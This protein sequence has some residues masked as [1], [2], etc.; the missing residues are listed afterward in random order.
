MNMNPWI[1]FEI[2]VNFFQSSLIVYFFK[3]QLN[4]THTNL[5]ADFSCIFCITSWYTLYLFLDIPLID[6]VVFLIPFIYG[7]LAFD[8]KWYV[9]LFWTLIIALIFSGGANL[10]IAFY[11]GVFG[12]GLDEIMG[13]THYRLAFVVSANILLLVSVLAVTKLR[14]RDKALPWHSFLPL[15]LLNILCLVITELLFSM[16]IVH[17]QEGFTYA[18]ICLFFVSI[19]S[20]VLYEVMAYTAQRHQQDRIEIERLTT[21]QKYNQEM[22]AVYENIAAFKH[23]IK[24]QMEALTQ[25]VS[26]TGV[27]DSV[28]IQ[29][30]DMLNAKADAL[31]PFATG[32]IAIDALLTAKMSSMK[33]YGVILDFRPCPLNE[34]P[35]EDSDFCTLLGNI[36][37]NALEGIC[38]LPKTRGLSITLSLIR[39]WDMFYIKC[40]NPTNPDAIRRVHGVFISSKVGMNHGIGMRSID[41]IAKHANGFSRFSHSDGTFHVEVVLPYDTIKKGE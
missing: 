21:T 30:I 2:L 12:I 37:D 23:D 8:D 27:R 32:N 10:T 15:I 39:V 6:T 31:Q 1:A 18:C 11:T 4:G 33:Q 19:L 28:V 17:F 9:V 34:L 35:I 29:N 14:D 40:E 26:I 7:C 25:M 16:E 36:L 22:Q 38:R 24:H 41:A 20:I 3:K 13:Q 5:T